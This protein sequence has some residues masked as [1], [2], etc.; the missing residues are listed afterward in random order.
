MAMLPRYI[1]KLHPQKSLTPY[2]VKINY[3]FYL[4][5]NY[6]PIT[7]T[8]QKWRRS[9]DQLDSCLST[10]GEIQTMYYPHKH[11]INTSQ[12]PHGIQRHQITV[13]TEILIH[14][15]NGLHMLPLL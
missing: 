7:K 15:S 3:K 10:P 13:Q 2:Q 14:L 5:S 9:I 8:L 6:I 11:Q 4:L 12:L 1:F